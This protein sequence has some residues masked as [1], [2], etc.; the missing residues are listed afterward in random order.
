MNQLSSS[1]AYL[2]QYLLLSGQKHVKQEVKFRFVYASFVMFLKKLMIMV[3]K[4]QSLSFSAKKSLL[5]AY[6]ELLK[7]VR[8]M[9]LSSWRFCNLLLLESW[10]IEQTLRP[11]SLWMYWD[12]PIIGF[13]FLQRDKVAY[14]TMY[15][16][17]GDSYK[18]VA[19]YDCI[20]MFYVD[21]AVQGFEYWFLLAWT[22]QCTC[23]APSAGMAT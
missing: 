18:C 13:G 2:N 7:C 15:D 14:I 20:W 21:E 6:D 22:H 9:L 5:V 4:P 11:Q 3:P 17:G 12:A 8:E 1:Y 19:L 23:L 10:R 16:P